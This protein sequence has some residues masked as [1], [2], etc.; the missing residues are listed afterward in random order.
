VVGKVKPHAARSIKLQVRPS[1][2]W[3]T[4]G[5][6]QSSD[7][8]KFTLTFTPSAAGTYSVRVR[9]PKTKD[10]KSAKSDVQT[11]K[12]EQQSGPAP[13]GAY[14]FQALYLVPSDKSPI[15]DEPAAISNEITQVN[16]WFDS[17]TVDG[18]HPRFNLD[19]AGA[20]SVVTVSM[21]HTAAE[22]EASSS[23][24]KMIVDD[25]VSLG[26]PKSENE[27]IAAFINVSAS[28]QGCGV[29]GYGLSLFPEDEC[30][31]HPSTT[32]TFPFGAT[33]LTA[34]EITHNLG[35]VPD[36]APHSDGTGHVNDDPRDV[37]YSGPQARDF[38]HITLDPGHDD[39]YA[40]GRTDCTDI[41]NSPYWT[42]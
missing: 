39:Y 6:T 9:A 19:S 30:D 7:R 12:V 28:G 31:I 21:P 32:D 34:H 15:A 33:Y 4:V 13:G 16:G 38:N 14:S 3:T 35:A 26:W 25:L 1:G 20:P 29:T 36:C 10:L 8:G 2:K 40:T 37:L 27:K 18:T 22:Y 11:L 5:Q 17:Q 24:I 23:Q 41:A 42:H